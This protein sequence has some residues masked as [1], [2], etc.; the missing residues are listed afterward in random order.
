MQIVCRHC[1][2]GTRRW[3]PV[4]LVILPFFCSFLSS[5]K[6]AVATSRMCKCRCVCSKAIQ[7]IA[8]I[9]IIGM[10]DTECKETAE[11]RPRK[12][13]L[14]GRL[15]NEAKLSKPMSKLGLCKARD[16]KDGQSSKQQ[17]LDLEV[18]LDL[19]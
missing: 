10:Q 9:I 7:T 3:H 18:E 14:H 13:R 19:E 4:P 15:I 11:G 2:S 12:S 5:N 17:D 1:Q 16:M 8:G 6:S